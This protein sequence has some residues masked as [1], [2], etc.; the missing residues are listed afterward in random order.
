MV[1]I[2][3]L[4]SAMNSVLIAAEPEPI[5]VYPSPGKEAFY[6]PDLHRAG[7]QMIKA[8][9]GILGWLTNSAAILAALD[10]SKPRLA[11]DPRRQAA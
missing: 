11:D 10:Q 2:L 3:Q 6:A 7:L 4:S 1:R 8:Q 9:G 5:A